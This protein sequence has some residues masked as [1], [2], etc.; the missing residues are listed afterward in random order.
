MKRPKSVSQK[1]A[2]GTLRPCRENIGANPDYEPAVAEDC[3]DW[4]CADGRDEWA[5]LYPTLEAA[6]ALRSVD[7]S[8]FAVLCS[9]WGRFVVAM[10]EGQPVTAAELSQLRRMYSDFGLTPASAGAVTK[11]EAKPDNPVSK[12]MRQ[13]A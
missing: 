10:R 13:V 12:L 4:L 6:G 5:R 11:V 9:M 8:M 1:E 2:A 7:L 3:P